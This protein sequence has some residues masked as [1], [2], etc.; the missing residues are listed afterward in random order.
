MMA[1]AASPKLPAD[2]L[3]RR[4]VGLVVDAESGDS[5][6]MVSVVYKRLKESFVTRDYGDFNIPR[7]EG[8]QLTLSAVGYKTQKIEID[9]KVKD[10]LLIKLK[11]DSKHL[12]QVEVK[13]KKSKYSRK[14]NPA[15]ELM[16]RVIAANKANDLKKTHAYYKYNNYQKIT[17]AI[18]DVNPSVLDQ[19]KSK[20]KKQWYLDQLMVCDQNGKLILP[21]NVEE[22][23]TEKAYR[24]ETNTERNTVTGHKTEG[25]TDLVDAGVIV[26]KI[27]EEVFSDVDLYNDQI[28]LLQ[29]PFTSPIGKNAIAFYRF[30]IIDTLM[31]GNERCIHLD[32]IPNNQQDFGFRG[33]LYVLADTSLHVRRCQLTIP[34]KSDV[35]WV[36]AMTIDL[37][38]EKLPSGEWVLTQDDMFCELSILQFIPKAVAFRTTRRTDYSFDPL[39]DNLFSGMGKDR[40]EE[41]SGRRD[42]K[43]WEEH[44]TVELNKSEE[45]LG[46]FISGMKKGTLTG[47][48]LAALK[49]VTDNFIGTGSKTS[50]SKVDIG[51]ITSLMSYNFVDGVRTRLGFVTTPF[52]FK[53]WFLKA[54]GAR[55]WKSKN[56]YYNAELTYSFNKKER[57]VDEYP[58]RK[59]Y[60]SS[61]FDNMAPSDRF[62][63]HDKDNIFTMFKWTTDNKRIFYVQHK[64]GFEYE[65]LG[66]LEYRF[67]YN[68]EDQWGV[69]DIEFP[70]MRLSEF[71]FGIRYAPNE[72]VVNTKKQRWKINKDTPIFELKHTMGVKGFLGGSQRYNT[73]EGSIYYRKWLNSWGKLSLYAAGGIQWNRVPYILLMQPPVN[74]ALVA[75]DCTFNLMNDMEFLNDRYAHVDI[76]WDVNGKLF[77][78]IPLLKKLKWRELIGIKAYWGWLSEKNRPIP[79]PNGRYVDAVDNSLLW[80]YGVNIMGKTP[81]MELNIGIHNIFNLFCVEYVRRLTYTDL[82]NASKHGV[83]FRFQVSF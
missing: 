55:G 74:T 37:E 67:H 24:R 58:K 45:H 53:K 9:S 20:K 40:V 68:W 81:Y 83:R 61:A 46:T 59:I 33:S 3:Q 39:P 21:V 82:P 72:A 16:E 75:Q 73:T 50:P 27:L 14:N 4:L 41:E 32:F 54:Y 30:Y 36:D 49:I 42:E 2:S 28:R 52:L 1:H 80:P 63:V 70:T 34:K 47:V 18:N 44:R 17:L 79:L 8:E 77:N 6:A 38:Y 65:Q 76:E 15:V 78:R 22:T 35:N 62:G 57:T 51:P 23:V 25:V 69:G 19:E 29:Y 48:L 7:Y 64:L 26:N 31:V 60:V 5:I 56:M 12:K 71:F 13:V 11:P 10:T 43:F 66:G